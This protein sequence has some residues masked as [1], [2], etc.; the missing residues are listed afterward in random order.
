MLAGDARVDVMHLPTGHPL[1]VLNRFANRARGLLDVGNDAATHA[2]CPGLS[3]TEDLE[4]RMLRQIA[5]DFAD[6]GGGFG[7][8]DIESRD[9]PVRIHWRRAIT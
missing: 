6:H 9:E 2:R 5:D 1:G 3:D 4:R 7:G 8:P